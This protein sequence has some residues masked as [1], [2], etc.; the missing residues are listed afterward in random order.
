MQ[1]FAQEVEQHET[2]VLGVQMVVRAGVSLRAVLMKTLLASRKSIISARFI[3]ALG[4][5][6][7][8]LE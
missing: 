2:L 4:P 6:Y 5:A 3:F 8:Q 7:V 1:R